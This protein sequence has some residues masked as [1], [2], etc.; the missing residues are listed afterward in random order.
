MEHPNEQKNAV[1]YCRVSTKEQ[2]EE[3]NSLV[4]QERLCREYAVKHQYHVA[5]IFIEQGESAKT[6][7]RTELRKLLSFCAVKKNNIQAIIIY[8]I[9]RLSR[10]IDDYSQIRINLKRY[11]VEIKSTSEFFENSPAGRFMENI[12]ANV[13]QFDNDVRTERCVGGMKQAMQEGRY[14]WSA[15]VG[16]T[17]GRIN[18]RANLVL[19][20]KAPLVVQTFNEVASGIFSVN[21]VRLRMAQR[22]LTQG[23][24]KPFAKSR[25]YRLLN[26]ITYTGNIASFGQ[27]IKGSFEPIISEELYNQVQRRI[28]SKKTSR[29]YIIENPDFPLRRFV[30]S[31]TG[32]KL[33]GSWSQGKR[34]KYPYYRFLRL[35]QEYRKSELEELFLQFLNGFAMPERAYA[36]IVNKVKTIL[37]ECEINSKAEIQSYEN[38]K[39]QL[40]QKKQVILEKNFSGIISDAILKE[41]LD[42][43]ENELWQTQK[44]LE[45]SKTG[46]SIPINSILGLK[47]F[48]T[49]PGVYWQKLP[50]ELKK[51]IQ[52][53]EFPKGVTFDGQEFRTQEICNI[54]KLNSLFTAKQF[55][56]VDHPEHSYRHLNHANFSALSDE[57][58]LAVFNKIKNDLTELDIIINSQEEKVENNDVI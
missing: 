46:T 14:V 20:D 56:V 48:F 35:N 10:N 21:E 16:Y 28:K 38:K 34:K 24:G 11:G 7:D 32:E 40:Q 22:G 18:G 31:H 45:V 19:S 1:I 12:L 42:L 15:P 4:T 33:T 51:K 47:E 6:A 52:V 44:M 17:N 55:R 26:N 53:F 5:H 13:A 3:G 57:D 49:N 41:Q 23:D 39:L 9:D 25:F 30:F 43:I 50:F 54:F 2:V 27:R 36:Y 8:K 37:S 29:N 58:F